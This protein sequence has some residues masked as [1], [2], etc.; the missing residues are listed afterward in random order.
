[1]RDRFSIH[2]MKLVWRRHGVL[3]VILSVMRA[4]VVGMIA[5]FGCY[6]PWL[7]NMFY[8]ALSI[9]YEPGNI[10]PVVTWEIVG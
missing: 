7:G 8:I 4:I 9:S 6:W 10:G 3:Y 5:A 1:M 2:T